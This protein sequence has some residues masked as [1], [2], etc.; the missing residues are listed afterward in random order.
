MTL[1][2]SSP[3]QINGD[4]VTTA[5]DVYALG[6][7]LYELLTSQKAQDN[8][9]ETHADFIRSV[10]DITPAKPSELKLRELVKFP[11][12]CGVIEKR[13]AFL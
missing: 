4:S 2:Y 1:A 11:D 6:L 9:T 3:E 8:T 10:T 5:T 13:K 12:N 7:I